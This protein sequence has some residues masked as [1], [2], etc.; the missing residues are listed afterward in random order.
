MIRVA[1]FLFVLL[2]AAIARGAIIQDKP[3]AR[4]MESDV[5]IVH[6][7]DCLL[8]ISRLRREQTGDDWTLRLT[9]KNA[10]DTDVSLAELLF[11]TFS[12]ERVLRREERQFVNTD[13]LPVPAHETKD[14]AL[15]LP[16]ITEHEHLGVAVSV[17]GRPECD[18]ARLRNAAVDQFAPPGIVLVKATGSPFRVT[19]ANVAE[20]E[21]GITRV[22]YSMEDNSPQPAN[23]SAQVAVLFFEY[24]ARGVVLRV[25][26]FDQPRTFLPTH[27]SGGSVTLRLA[28]IPR[29]SSQWAVAV[30]VTTGIFTKLDG[31]VQQWSAGNENMI[32]LAAMYNARD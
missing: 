15:V 30:M 9:L 27:G 14:T 11:Y 20:A 12:H 7:G 23:D 4:P 25:K 28:P 3:T 22:T 18:S 31:S 24:S 17:P 1:A 8:T 2:L 29:P 16:I 26:T 32:A 13:D 10:S 21:P 19:G 5:E 6:P